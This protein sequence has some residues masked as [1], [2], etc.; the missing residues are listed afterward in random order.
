MK[1]HAFLRWSLAALG[2][3]MGCG[4][5]IWIV[6]WISLRSSAV[7]VPDLRG[8]DTAHAT[9]DLQDAGLVV[10]IQDGVFDP[11]VEV[12]RVA[13]QRPAAGFG[14]KRGGA[15]MVYPSLGKAVQR[16]ADL[17]GLPVAV[18]ENELENGK[19]T[20][21]RR[22][23][24]YGQ[25][26]GVVVVAQ[27]PPADSLVAPGSA[28]TLLVNRAAAI[29]RYIMPEF[30]GSNEADAT[31]VIRALGFQLAEVQQVR[32]P[33][34]APGVVLRQEP[35]SGGPVTAGAVVALWVSR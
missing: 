13:R 3:V 10:R 4:L 33:G 25:A 30:V 2:L 24:V 7:K 34:V 14:L 8:M 21:D 1:A 22:C 35:S 11:A 16:V 6:L 20:V 31:R 32:Y 29:A 28:V 9:A 17:T 15:V 19:L 23:E 27:A 12:G 26:D 18:A 5:A